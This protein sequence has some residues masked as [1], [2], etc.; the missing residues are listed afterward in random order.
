MSFCPRWG[1][2]TLTNNNPRS[3]W[4]LRNRKLNNSQSVQRVHPIKGR[5]S[6]KNSQ[7][8]KEKK[9]LKKSTLMDSRNSGSAT[10]HRTR[11]HK[12][13]RFHRIWKASCKTM[14]ISQPTKR[15]LDNRRI[16]NKKWKVRLRSS[17]SRMMKRSNRCRGK[18]NKVRLVLSTLLSLSFW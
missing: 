3:Q 15:K 16:L 11:Q 2:E 12:E 9:K 4:M 10:T 17:F 13:R 7:K 6:S 14:K 1:N 8:H 18:R 5:N